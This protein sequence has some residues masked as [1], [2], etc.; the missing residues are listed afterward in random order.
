LDSTALSG[1]LL[2]PERV[3]GM[4]GAA[5][6]VQ[7]SF[8]DSVIDDS[9]KLLQKDCIGVMAP[10]QHRVYGDAGWTGVRSQ[11]LR[12]AGEG[13]RIYAVIQAVIS[14]PNADA[15]KKLLADQQ[16]QWASCSGRTLTLTFPTPPSPQLWIAGTP[17]DMDGTTTMTQTLKD[18]GGMQC[19][20][21][22]AV[23][24]NVAVDVSACRYD[25]A[26]QALDIV[27]GIAAKIPG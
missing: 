10:A 16:S 4:V 23:R 7:E 20:R 11:A 21:A 8:A 18:G 2:S 25:T 26:E 6:L 15:A 12:N 3:A 17:A 14:F 5:A 22:L 27:H 19:Q 24:N 13:P 9:E 1:L